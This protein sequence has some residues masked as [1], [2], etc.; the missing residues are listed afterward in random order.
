MD[1]VS[2]TDLP[3]QATLDSWRASGADRLDRVRFCFIEAL[4]RRTSG[5]T[6]EVRR[7]LE[8]R[9]SEL[10]AAYAEDIDRAAATADATDSD[11]PAGSALA[12]LLR[13]IASRERTNVGSVAEGRSARHLQALP[14]LKIL[15]D[16][17]DTWSRVSAEKQLR[18][19]LDKVPVNA[20]PLNSSSLVHRSL[21]LM[22]AVSPDYLRQFLAYVDALSWLERMSGDGAAGGHEAARSGGKARGKAR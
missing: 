5:Q 10:V 14:E 11:A 13:D 19:A 6:G 3:T 20:G 15:E 12:E 4:H 7:M 18:D 22:R 17:R 1:A 16:V 9:L 8:A 2:R 21:L